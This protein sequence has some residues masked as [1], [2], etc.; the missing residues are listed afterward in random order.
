[1]IFYFADCT[2]PFSINF[3]T[4]TDTDNSAAGTANTVI[5]QGI[6]LEYTQLAC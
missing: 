6:C 1:M 5:S 2:Q 4:D 3:V